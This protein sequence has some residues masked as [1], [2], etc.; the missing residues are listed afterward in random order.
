[1]AHKSTEYKNEK[2]L[3]LI[4]L[5]IFAA[6]FM[7]VAIIFVSILVSITRVYVKESA[8][9]EVEQQS[10]FLLQTI[11]R[12]V[13][14]SS[15]LDD[16]A[17]PHGAQTSTLVLRTSGPSDKV[18]IY[19]SSTTGIV[20]LDE[21][22][23]NIGVTTST[24]LTTES[25]RV[26]DLSF[27][28]RVN[29]PG[30]DS[31]SFSFTAAYNT[32]N[33]QQ[34]FSQ[35]LN[36]AVSRVMAATFEGGVYPT[37]SAVDKRIGG[38][39]SNSWKSIN[40]VIYFSG[41]NVGI[42]ETLPSQKLEVNGGFGVNNGNIKVSN[43]YIYAGTEGQGIIVKNSSGVCYRING[44]FIDGPSGAIIPEGLPCP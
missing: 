11:Q 20:Y 41:T 13:E 12:Y 43:G 44:D 27:T 28:R 5:I 26:S 19:T 31:V 7:V 16:V 8:S 14:Q 39:D 29:S 24:P 40:D 9:A 4:E 34:M 32:V 18:R 42:G 36:S 2:G 30:H 38:S 22:N 1:M 35:T 10:H 17:M 3:T 6:I 23:T 37:P 33:P 25:V 21:E 15:V